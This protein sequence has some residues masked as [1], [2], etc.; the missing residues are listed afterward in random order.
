M[1]Y[2]G[3]TQKKF[4]NTVRNKPSKAIKILKH[5]PELATLTWKGKSSSIPGSTAL[6]WAAHNGHLELVKILLELGADIN[7]NEADWWCR[8]IDWAADSGKYE[9]VQ[10]LMLNGAD[11]GGDKWSNCTPLH[12][13]AQGGSSNGKDRSLEY[14]KTTEI[15]IY[16][17]AEVNAI[18]KYGGQPPEMT[19]LDDAQNVG[20]KVVEEVLLKYGGKTAEQLRVT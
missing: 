9:V 3:L 15:L 11:F 12:V 14:Q 8:P 18:A 6:H 20:N 2:Q 13:V 16:G 19:P 10:Y 1:K 5:N 17:G 4:F 7:A